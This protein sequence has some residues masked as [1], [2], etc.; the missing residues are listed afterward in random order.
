MVDRHRGVAH[1]NGMY[2]K[3]RRRVPAIPQAQEGPIHKAYPVKVT[4]D[5]LFSGTID[6]INRFV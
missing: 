1:L 5:L 2:G 4:D 6:N 3:G